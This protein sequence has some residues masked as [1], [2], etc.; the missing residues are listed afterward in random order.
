MFRASL[1]FH[2]GLVDMIKVQLLLNNETSFD[3]LSVLSNL[4]PIQN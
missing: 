4:N 1:L 2:R 3:T